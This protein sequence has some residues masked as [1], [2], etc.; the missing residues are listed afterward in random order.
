MNFKT[1]QEAK[2]FLAKYSEKVGF[3]VKLYRERPKSK[4]VNCIKEGACKFYKPGEDRK[5]KK[6]TKRNMCK[7][8]ILLKKVRDQSGSIVSYSIDYVNLNH[9]HE[10]LQSQLRTMCGSRTGG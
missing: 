1:P 9:N 4:W 5:R 3:G 2:K 6:I 8:A 10:L 7:A